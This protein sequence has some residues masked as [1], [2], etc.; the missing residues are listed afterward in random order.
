M[1]AL[2]GGAALPAGRHRMPAASSGQVRRRRRRLSAGG[3]EE[4]AT[5]LLVAAASCSL[6]M[7]LGSFRCASVCPALI[8]ERYM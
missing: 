4:C 7:T 5:R 6:E 8:G 1:N 2:A 3:A